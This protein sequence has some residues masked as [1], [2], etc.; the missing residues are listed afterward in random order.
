[1]TP[2]RL[3]LARAAAMALLVLAFTAN[4][5]AADDGSSSDC[6]PY[7]PGLPN[8]VPSPPELGWPFTE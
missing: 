8:V 2:L 7:D 1:M 5:A 3:R 6:V 4:A